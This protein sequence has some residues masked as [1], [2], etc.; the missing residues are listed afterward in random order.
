MK[1]GINKRENSASCRKEEEKQ[2]RK[3]RLM[4][5]GTTESI[6]KNNYMKL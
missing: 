1:G 3:A 2:R 6:Q 5:T 4:E